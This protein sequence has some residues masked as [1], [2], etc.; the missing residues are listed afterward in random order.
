MEQI[1]DGMIFIWPQLRIVFE[2]LGALVV[3]GLAIVKA[4]P[5]KAD[6][7]FV[8]KFMGGS[9]GALMRAVA[10]FSPIQ[11]NKKNAQS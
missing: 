10:S 11:V 3:V 7:A 9:I 4:T 6:D 2:I 5:T 1:L 8:N